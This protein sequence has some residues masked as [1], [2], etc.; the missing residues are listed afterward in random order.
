M[1]G[2]AGDNPGA[3]GNN[4]G[5][6]TQNQL[7]GLLGVFGSGMYLSYTV[8]GTYIFTVPLG[9]TSIRVRVGGAA[10]SGAVAIGSSMAAALGGAGGGWAIN[11][12]SVTPNTSYTVTIG[13]GGASVFLTA[14][15]AI[16]GN[17]GGTS[18]FGNLISATGGAGGVV[19]ISA[20]AHSAAIPGVGSGGS[21]NY[22][23]G[24]G[25]AVNNTGAVSSLYA[26]GGGA[27]GS[28]NG[29]GGNGGS[30]TGSANGYYATAG[31]A[32][33]Q[34]H[35]ASI[36]FGSATN[37]NNYSGGGAGVGG[38]PATTSGGVTPAA[39]A[40]GPDIFG[41]IVYGAISTTTQPAVNGSAINLTIPSRFLGD[42]LFGA[43]GAGIVNSSV[44][45]IVGGN[46][47]PGAGGGA[48]ENNNSAGYGGNGGVFGGGGA[49]LDIS[50]GAY[51]Y[52]G[53]GGL[54]AGGAGLAGNPSSASHD[55]SGKGGDGY[56]VVEW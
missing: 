13:A 7:G 47:G 10:G 30:I 56:C 42:Q 27:G 5:R 49:I 9:V 12:F 33:G 6:V 51:N 14:T 41:N 24:Y 35:A 19:S 25:G 53:N 45:P 44:N 39:L 8:A 11:V 40:G 15:G 22:S 1:G 31:G 3:S 20:G 55:Y 52:A 46:G 21:A 34:S 18:S 36:N 17:A 26:T 50:T 29:N 23:G 32:V 4:N 16:N 48:V 43:G 38:S 37:F 2:F 54:C 28:Q